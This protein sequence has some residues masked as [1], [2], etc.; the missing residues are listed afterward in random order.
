MKNSKIIILSLLISIIILF[1]VQHF[2]KVFEQSPLESD[3]LYPCEKNYE[4]YFEPLPYSFDKNYDDKL[5]C[6]S[7]KTRVTF[8]NPISD[9]EYSTDYFKTVFTFPPFSTTVIFQTNNNMKN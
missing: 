3:G 6:S 2:G 8:N 7:L 4:G 9:K 1:I 5:R